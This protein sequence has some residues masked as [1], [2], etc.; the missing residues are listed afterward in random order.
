MNN[1]YFYASCVT[2]RAPPSY[3]PGMSQSSARKSNTRQGKQSKQGVAQV[4]AQAREDWAL[5]NTAGFSSWVTSTFERITKVGS[6]PS[7]ADGLFPQQRFAREYMALDSPY[8]GIILY[9]GLG[10][11]KTCSAIAVA[12]AVRSAAAATTT[13]VNSSVR[14][15]NS[16]YILLPASLRGNYLKEVRKCGAQEFRDAQLWTKNPE[17][18]LWTPALDKAADAKH[19]DDLA[20]AERT[21]LRKQIDD[22]IANVHKVVAYNGLRPASISALLE[23]ANGFDDS[24]VIVD[25]VHN[26]VR[27]VVNGG[28]LQRLYNALMEAKRCK[29]VLLSGTP[30]VNRPEELAVLANLAHGPILIHD[31]F[32][33]GPLDDRA[34]AQ[35]SACPELDE[36]VEDTRAGGKN[37]VAARFLPDGFVR[38]DVRGRVHL[39]R[40][41]VSSTS[42]RDNAAAAAAATQTGGTEGD[43][44]GIKRVQEILNATVGLVKR[45]PTLRRVLLL[46]V[47]PVEFRDAFIDD[48]KNVVRNR[49]V[50]ERRLSGLVS[51]FSGH[52]PSLYPLVQTMQIIR[53]PLSARQFAEYMLHRAGEIKREDAA[54]RFAAAAG[55]RLGAAAAAAQ[56]DDEGFAGY[57]PLSRAICNFAFPPDIP[58]PTRAAILRARGAAQMENDEDQD[59]NEVA[60]NQV[61]GYDSANVEVGDVVDGN[62]KLASPVSPDELD[63]PDVPHDPNRVYPPIVS[64]A[65]SVMSVTK[66]KG[67]HVAESADAEYLA[68]LD[69]MVEKLKQDPKRLKLLTSS[70]TTKSTKSKTSSKEE[71]EEKEEGI[72]ALSP[73]FASVARSITKLKEGTAIVYSQFRRAEG[74]NL[75]GATLYANGFDELRVVRKPIVTSDNHKNKQQPSHELRVEL[76]PCAEHA[77][78]QQTNQQTNKIYPRFV[79]YSNDDPMVAQVV[80]SIFNNNLQDLPASVLADLR[81][82][83]SSSSPSNLHGELIRVLMITQSG[84]EGIT[85]RNV[86]QVHV[87]EPFWHANRVQQVIGRAV[88]AHSHDQLPENE[89][90]VDVFIHIAT[91]SDEQSKV[92]LVKRDGNK[93]SDEY[94]HDVAQRKRIL[95]STLL[96]VMRAASVDCRLHAARHADAA[97]KMAERLGKSGS[98][99]KTSKTLRCF[100]PSPSVA[101]GDHIYATSYK[102][103]IKAA[104]AER[105]RVQKNLVHVQGPDGT[106]YFADPKTGQLYDAKALE[107]SGDLVIIGKAKK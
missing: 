86:R 11:G 47:D 22:A 59:G 56:K 17:T 8:R 82:K 72:D 14:K 38:G 37:V 107:D 99:S 43:N 64:S 24:T 62:A 73:K 102:D 80:L 96:D 74:I 89:R 98:A 57:R 34:I 29:L 65:M 70:S 50:L 30:L 84:A 67:P 25:E 40:N 18:G 28:Q 27:N 49:S 41:I 61:R 19:Y 94:V 69:A 1:K 63:F 31:F 21:E 88:R 13:L 32:V 48:T 2:D 3:R 76:I 33:R 106:E 92:P 83:S 42:R 36:F 93:T 66:G 95:L 85:T 97:K 4:Q 7:D 35:L 58:R 90:T 101:A 105:A 20:P 10:S 23:S 45:D 81:D 44:L 51:Y 53:S 26:F 79:T 104:A 77:M 78:N 91:F 9:H 60:R 68:A 71:K 39:R 16:V 12:E 100:A 75:M 46:P 55:R 6:D 52:D 103:D 5:P 87:L 15:N 54:K